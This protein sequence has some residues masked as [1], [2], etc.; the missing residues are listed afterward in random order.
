MSGED[1]AQTTRG[2]GLRG[3]RREQPRG[4]QKRAAVGGDELSMRA[5]VDVEELVLLLQASLQAFAEENV[6]A[7]LPGGISGGLSNRGVDSGGQL[8]HRCRSRCPIS[9]AS[10][11][12]KSLSG[13]QAA[14]SDERELR[15][16]R[17]NRSL[18]RRDTT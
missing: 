9:S 5:L 10:S 1:V 3:G 18:P 11:F 7:A 14:T 4:L 13:S 2:L 12:E 8:P 16:R 6:R 17:V 15:S